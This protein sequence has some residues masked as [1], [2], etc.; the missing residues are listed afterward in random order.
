MVSA[1]SLQYIFFFFVTPASR[2][3]CSPQARSIPTAA[4]EAPPSQP[5]RRPAPER[6]RRFPPPDRHRGS[7]AGVPAWGGEAGKERKLQGCSLRQGLPYLSERRVA[8]ACSFKMVP[9][10]NSE[11]GVLTAAPPIVVPTN[12]RRLRP[13]WGWGSCMFTESE[14][15]RLLAAKTGRPPASGI[16]APKNADAVGRHTARVAAI[17]EECIAV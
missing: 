13:A 4:N 14:S 3:C 5:P 16:G 2:A 8:V 6:A 9:G 17:A 15:A 1:C 7:G 10:R 12:L 11:G